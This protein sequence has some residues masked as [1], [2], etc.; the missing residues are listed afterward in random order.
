MYCDREGSTEFI[1]IERAAL[2]T[3]TS[4]QIRMDRAVVRI[5]WDREGSFG[6][7]GIE[8]AALC[9]AT[10]RQIRMGRVDILG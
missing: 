8:R 2:C 5:H 9:A 4:R 6:C 7:I 10:S 1:A 3:D